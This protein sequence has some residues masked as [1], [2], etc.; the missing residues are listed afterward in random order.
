MLGFHDPFQAMGGNIFE[1]PNSVETL[2]LPSRYQDWSYTTNPFKNISAMQSDYHNYCV[3]QQASL[4]NQ[5]STLIPS[6]SYDP[7]MLLILNNQVSTSM[8][9]HQV[10]PPMPFFSNDPNKRQK[11]SNDDHSFR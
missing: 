7:N 4:N 10:S 6:P 8:P 9:S 1:T 2:T 3:Y 11:L 5:V